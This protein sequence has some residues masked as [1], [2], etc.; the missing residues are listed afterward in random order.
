[1]VQAFAF[2]IMAKKEEK[3]RFHACGRDKAVILR[4]LA[5]TKKKCHR[6]EVEVRMNL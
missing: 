4:N 3:I 5:E 6:L 2:T 1:M